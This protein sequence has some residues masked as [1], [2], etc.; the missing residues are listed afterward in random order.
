VVGD[1]AYT[2][3]RPSG[4]S[5]FRFTLERSVVAEQL[6]KIPDILDS[7]QA[8]RLQM[9]YSFDGTQRSVVMYPCRDF[10]L[11]NFVAIVPDASL[12]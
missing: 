2:S 5:A 8:A 3:A 10:K 4:L 9:V 6:G 12:K 11:L 7:N 1:A